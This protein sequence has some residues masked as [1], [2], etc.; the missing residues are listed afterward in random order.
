MAHDFELDDNGNIRMRPVTA[1]T[2]HLIAGIAALLRI[3]YV[4]SPEEFEE[5]H[6]VLQLALT[7]Q[8]CLELAESLSNTGKQLLHIDPSQV[9]Q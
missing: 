6:K 5:R 2:T 4:E 1:W 8:Q 3:E 9:Q 7:A